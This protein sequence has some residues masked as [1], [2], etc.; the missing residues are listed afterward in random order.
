M[1]IS[2]LKAKLS[3]RFAFSQDDVLIPYYSLEAAQGHLEDLADLQ[4]NIRILIELQDL[5]SPKFLQ[6]LNLGFRF[7]LWLETKPYLSPLEHLTDKQ[8]SQIRC[9]FI[10]KS[11]H[12]LS[13]KKPKWI[14]E[15]VFGW[16]K[17]TNPV[18]ARQLLVEMKLWHLSDQCRNNPQQI[19][20][21][22]HEE[23]VCFELNPSGL[24][25]LSNGA[26]SAF[27]LYCLKSM[28]AF[29]F[30]DLLIQFLFQFC[31][32]T[33]P[34]NQRARSFIAKAGELTMAR[35]HGE[36]WMNLICAQLGRR[37]LYWQVWRRL[38][39]HQICEKLVYNYIFWRFLRSF[40]WHQVLIEKVYWVVCQKFLYGTLWHQFL[41]MKVYWGFLYGTLWHQIMIKGIYWGIYWRFIRGFIWH[42]LIRELFYWN[43]VNQL[44]WHQ[45][46]VKGIYWGIYW[47]FIRETLYWNFVNQLV[48]HQI[49]VKGIYWGIYWR[50]IRETLYWNFVNQL[51]W[52]QILVK[53]IYWGIYW[54]FIR[55]FIWHQLIIKTLYW[56]FV[57]QFLL[58]ILWG[59]FA[60]GIIYWRVLHDFLLYPFFKLYWFFE[61]QFKTR[62][63]PWLIQNR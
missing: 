59:R 51:V 61:Y 37:F 22:G 9:V 24:G 47:R 49:L 46:V 28:K 63:H 11:A 33:E 13:S 44:V 55:G 27:L 12:D 52:H 62:I 29:F 21:L 8:R 14:N 17:Y 58:G 45:I 23:T 16:P 20:H 18:K 39:H 38:L 32:S 2:E 57:R 56:Q 3:A 60:I 42:R 31:V 35:L 25:L 50:F 6:L 41:V 30:F 40:L 4:N 48:W 43:F 54:R 26:R 53:G 7:D 15:S 10:L 36:I 19:L 5:A 34:P 1:S